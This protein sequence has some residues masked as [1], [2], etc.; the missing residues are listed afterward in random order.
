MLA[1]K[2]VSRLRIRLAAI[3]EEAMLEQHD[4]EISVDPEDFIIA[5]GFYR[6]DS[7]SDSYRWE[8]YAQIV[9]MRVKISLCSY[10]TMTK[11]VQS[12]GC[13]IARETGSQSYAVYDATGN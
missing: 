2:A 3:L 6:T 8:V 4:Q 1:P 9:G 11:I 7:R 12:K 10:T 5:E 13:V